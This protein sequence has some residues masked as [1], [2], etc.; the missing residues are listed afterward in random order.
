MIRASGAGRPRTTIV[1]PDG[2]RLL[3]WAAA[4]Q[5]MNAH[6]NALRQRSVEVAPGV[7]QVRATRPRGRPRKQP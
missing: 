4:E 3:G 5:A 1:L 2:R 7:W 6:R